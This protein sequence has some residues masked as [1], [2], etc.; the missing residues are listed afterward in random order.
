[1][2]IYTKL[3]KFNLYPFRNYST[4]TVSGYYNWNSAM[5]KENSLIN[6][7]NHAIPS[8]NRIRTIIQKMQPLIEY[9]YV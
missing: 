3:S 2:Y 6:G 9:Q 4:F 1:M 7:P 8:M 5:E